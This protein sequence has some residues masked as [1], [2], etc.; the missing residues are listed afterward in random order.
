MNYGLT[1]P[2]CHAKGFILKG[3]NNLKGRPEFIC[4]CCFHMWTYGADGEPF[5]SN[6]IKYMKKSGMEIPNKPNMTVDG[7]NQDF[8]DKWS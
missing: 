3:Y 8:I 2:S 7:F 4:Q 5:F 1:C 6:A